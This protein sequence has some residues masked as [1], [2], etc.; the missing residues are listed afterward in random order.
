M[1]EIRN[2]KDV[3]YMVVDINDNRHVKCLRKTG[4]LKAMVLQLEEYVFLRAEKFKMEIKKAVFNDGTVVVNPIFTQTHMPTLPVAPEGTH[5]SFHAPA[6]TEDSA[7]APQTQ[8]TAP[9]AD[10][11]VA[12]PPPPAPDT[13]VVDTPAADEQ[14]SDKEATPDEVDA[15]ADPNAEATLMETITGEGD[16][17]SVNVLTI[18][19]YATYNKAELTEFLTKLAPGMDEAVQ[20]QIAAI[21]KKTTQQQLLDIISATLLA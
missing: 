19:Q 16:R 6:M 5:L 21:T 17:V 11:V 3:K 7:P 14:S 8:E 18:E 13:T 1:N 4:P 10:P 12:P 15:P 20:T 2:E 9:A